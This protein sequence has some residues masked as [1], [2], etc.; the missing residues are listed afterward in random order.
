M[1]RPLHVQEP[2]ERTVFT[3]LVLAALLAS[4]C[5]RGNSAAP[6]VAARGTVEGGI[7]PAQEDYYAVDVV[8]SD[9]AWIVGSYGA[10]VALRDRGRTVELHPAPVHDPLFCVSF[11]DPSTGVIGGR[12]GRIFRTTDGGKSWSPAKVPGWTENVLAFARAPRSSASLGRGAEG[13]DAA[14]D[15]RRSD[16]GGSVT[17]QGHHAQ[18][19]DFRR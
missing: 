1:R 10:V 5:V 12:G 13:N 18:R 9:H 11:R 16:L 17:R 15:G 8:D 4:A 6:P 2:F 3:P 14:L 19:G 7:L